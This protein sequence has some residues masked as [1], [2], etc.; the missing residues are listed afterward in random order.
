MPQLV[1]R[2]DADLAAQIDAL[3]ASGEVESRSDAVRSGL[4]VL[5]EEKHRKDTAQ[6]II[7][8]YT[9]QPQVDREIGWSDRATAEMI[10]E[11]PW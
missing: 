10:A 7:K 9:D 11:E 2:I 1:T 4:R 3:I 5:L 8:G 6:A